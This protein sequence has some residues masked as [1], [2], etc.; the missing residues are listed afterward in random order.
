MRKRVI[1]TVLVSGIATIAFLGCYTTSK[2]TGKVAEQQTSITV[3]QKSKATHEKSPK[4]TKSPKGKSSTAGPL[5]ESILPETSGTAFPL[6]ES[7]TEKESSSP[8]KADNSR[9]YVCHL[10]FKFEEL[11]A[12]HAAAGVGCQTCHGPS[13]AHIADESWS[14][15]GKGTPPDRMYP[16]DKINESCLHCHK[17]TLSRQAE[18]QKILS[19]PVQTNTV[20]T[21][22]HGNHR[23]R[24]R[25]VHW[26]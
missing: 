16:R 25:K 23:L 11:A 3:I 8:T 4:P 22:C 9:C 5:P 15:G 17:S 24:I 19:R 7:L 10:N 1:L 2:E 12:R 21:D 6:P 14:W 26:K 18:H 13:D 20:C